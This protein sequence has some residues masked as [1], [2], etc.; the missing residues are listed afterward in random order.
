MTPTRE[1]RPRLALLSQDMA[2]PGNGVLS[3]VAFL[4]RVAVEAD[5]E[6][7][8]L[9]AATSARDEASL[10]LLAPASWRTGPR[11][12]ERRQPP[13]PPH[14]HF[15]ARGAELEFQR[16]RPRLELT[17]R[18]DRC[19]LVQVVAGTPAWADLAR[20]ARVPVALQLASL[21]RVERAS[22]LAAQRGARRIWTAAMTR[23]CAAAER[24]ALR[25]ADL[26]LVENRAMV[27]R[28]ERSPAAGRILWAPPGVDVERFRPADGPRPGYWLSVARFADPR[29]NLAL[30]LRAYAAAKSGRRDLPRLVLAGSS[31]PTAADLALAAELGIA[32]DLELRGGVSEADLPA[33]YQ[34]AALF[35][36]A[37]NEEGW[38]LVFVEAMASGLPVIA[39]RTDGAAEIVREGETGHL[40]AIG[41]HE[42]LARR[43]LE[44]HD[45]PEVARRLGARARQVAEQELSRAVCG[46][47]FVAAWRRLLADGPGRGAAGDAG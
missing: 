40:V 5:F 22:A 35:L 37:S 36:L 11:V 1:R 38:G 43:A 46:R 41:D 26:V 12:L 34:D 47:R 3:V 8:L 39:T 25:R 15:G 7:E 10:R 29:K 33:L 20:E 23:L 21:S 17:R 4:H 27:A 28:L 31:G 18:L 9:S 16:Y 13:L 32:T 2:Q 14:H 30:L 42:T 44:L 6:V 45:Q 19:A 24:R